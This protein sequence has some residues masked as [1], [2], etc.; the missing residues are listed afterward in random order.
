MRAR[1]EER[2]ARYLLRHLTRRI[3]AVKTL[4]QYTRQ[5]RQY[6]REYYTGKIDDSGFLD[7]T[8]AAIT[9]QIGRAWREGMRA[10][11][12]GPEDMDEEMQAQIDE[13]IRNEQ[14][15]LTNLSDLIN[16][17]RGADAGMDAINARCDTWA[18]RYTDVVNQ[19]KLA[20]SADNQRYIWVYGDT[21]HCETC[22]ALNDTVLTAKEWRE[23]KYHP[24]KPPNDELECGGWRCKCK[25]QK[26]KAKRT[27]LPDGL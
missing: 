7:K 24:Q 12:L 1:V 14:D 22:A 17:Q 13:I 21:E 5:L 4:E 20:T 15:H 8:L 9:E 6:S 27:G 2:I 11:G 10:N 3:E 16:Q 23:G 25:L 26:T 18:T 19:A